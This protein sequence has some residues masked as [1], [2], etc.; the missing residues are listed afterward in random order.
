MKTR[1]KRGS[2]KDT[3]NSLELLLRAIGDLPV[4]AIKPKHLTRFCDVLAHWPIYGERKAWTG[5]TIPESVAAGKREGIEPIGMMTQRRHLLYLTTFFHWSLRCRDTEQDPMRGVGMSRH[6]PK[7]V[8]KRK[9][10]Y[11]PDFDL[12]AAPARIAKIEEP[13]EFWGPLSTTFRLCAAT[14]PERVVF[15]LKAAR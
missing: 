12:I 6:S 15:E 13:V 3:C 10:M 5:L 11:K 14:R 8:E 1:T 9:V 7:I 2:A 4:R